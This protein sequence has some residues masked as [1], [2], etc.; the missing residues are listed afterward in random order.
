MRR[1]SHPAESHK[2]GWLLEKIA[3][4]GGSEAIEQ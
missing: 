3:A 2:P 4:D 1:V